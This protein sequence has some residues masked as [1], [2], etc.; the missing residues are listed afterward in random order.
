ME[1]IAGFLSQIPN[2]VYNLQMRAQSSGLE[3]WGVCTP[4]RGDSTIY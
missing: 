3:E 2:S 1:A 4:V